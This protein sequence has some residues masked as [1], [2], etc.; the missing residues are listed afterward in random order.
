[1]KDAGAAATKQCDLVLEGGLVSGLVH[2]AAVLELAKDYRF[3][4]VGGASAGAYVA[5]ATAAAEM[6][7]NSGGFERLARFSGE[8]AK[9]GLVD[10]LFQASPA[11]TPLLR[12]A[13]AAMGATS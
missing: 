5:A 4:R 12:V 3:R 13:L 2:P 11:T 10:Q 7:R 6:A 8:L 1:M 9:G